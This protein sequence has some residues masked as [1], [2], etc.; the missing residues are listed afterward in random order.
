[1]SSNSTKK[2]SMKRISAS[3]SVET[4]TELIKYAE[5]EG[6]ALSWVVRKALIEFLD[7]NIKQRELP[8]N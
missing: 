6:V 3:V 7:R 5:K 2:S 1:M 4:E 8:L